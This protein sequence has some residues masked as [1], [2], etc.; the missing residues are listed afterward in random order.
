MRLK[1]SLRN[2]TPKIYCQYCGKGRTVA[3]IGSVARCRKCGGF[4]NSELTPKV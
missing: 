4:I 2:K 3:N 1:K